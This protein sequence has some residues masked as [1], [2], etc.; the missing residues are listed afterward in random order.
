MVVVVPHLASGF[1]SD[2][3]QPA[4]TLAYDPGADRWRTLD[5][6]PAAGQQIL[7]AGTGEQPVYWASEERPGTTDWLLDPESGSWSR[8][9]ADPV[10]AT[11]DRTYVWDGEELIF[12]AL[13]S[14]GVDESAEHFYQMARLDPG[15]R[16]WTVE[17]ETPVSF[18]NPTWYVT[19]RQ[20][21][22]PTQPG[23]GLGRSPGGI[24]D[25]ATREWRPVPH[26]ALEEG[27][28]LA[29]SLPPIGPAGDWVAGGG[30]VLVSVAPDA[31]TWVP[32][33]APLSEPHVGVWTGEELIVYAGI[34]FS[35][36]RNLNLGL[37]WTPPPVE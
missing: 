33:C 14:S 9:P 23:Y 17:G 10:P 13:R 29:C 1:E 20:L 19:D 25:L 7:G 16:A 32:A 24:L 22:N 18:G 12:T 8:L 26:T 27:T 35:L 5:P 36:R 11:F 28:R 34:D 6:P 15:T 37:R 2:P 30:G 21:V 31:T 4:A 3:G